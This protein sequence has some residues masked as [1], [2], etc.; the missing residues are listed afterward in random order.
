MERLL[1]LFLQWWLL[2]KLIKIKQEILPR[3]ILSYCY[4]KACRT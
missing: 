2:K 3:L 1:Q 4:V